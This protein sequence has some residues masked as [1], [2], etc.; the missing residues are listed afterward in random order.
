MDLERE[1]APLN[2][3]AEVCIVGAGAAGIVLAAELLR[4]GKRVL[5][6]ESGGRAIE[7][8]V[9]QLNACT[10]SGQLRRGAHIGRFRTLGGTTTMWGGQVLEL[11]D[12]D[13]VARPWVPGS[14]WPFPKEELRP[15]Y[16]RALNAERLGR[17]IRSDSEVWREMKMT[18]PSLNDALEPYFTR[19]CPVSNFAWLYR[20][21]FESPNICVVLHATATAM[22]LHENGTRIR[23]VCCRTLDGKEHTFTASQYVLCLGTIETVRFLL[24]PLPGA[25]TPPWNASGLLGRHLQSHIDLDVAQV[26]AADARRLRSWFAN[27]YLRGYKYHPKI[28]LAFP[29]QRQQ[30][31][32]NIAGSVT[33][34][35]PDERELRR[36]KALARNIVQGR[37]PRIW[38]DL[39]PTLRR[40]SILLR[41]GYGYRVQR[42]AHWPK[43]SG[44]WLRVHCEQEPLSQSRITLINA[45]DATGLLQA[46]MDWQVSSFEWKTVRE[47]TSQAQRTFAT[48]GYAHMEPRPEIALENGYRDL[49]FDDSYH[50]MGGARMSRSAAE[51]V[52][53]TDLKLHGLDNVFVCSASVFPTSGFSNPTHT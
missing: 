21:T 12:E 15:F 34:I 20:E 10:Y 25:Q 37:A 22:L 40:L 24:Q 11:N 33:C 18:T 4:R 23:G 5:L 17:V 8:A 46:Q 35:N 28:R 14:G 27:A 16:E 26:P 52:V 41:M 31:T 30:A 36:A 2:F 1:P 47:F 51:G 50:W 13:F 43:N 44:F 29:V 9:Q 3:L 32:L 53:D 42:R 6:L 49:V 38:A 45:R 7:S 48:C 19:W 39:P